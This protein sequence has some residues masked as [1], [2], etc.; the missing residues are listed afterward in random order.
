MSDVA[1]RF[2]VGSQQ[3]I[4]T[5]FDVEPTK[6]IETEFNLHVVNKDHN[7]L[8]NRDLPNQHSMEAITGLTEA[9]EAKQDTLEAGKGI[10]ING[11][12]ISTSGDSVGVPQ[13]ANV[14]SQ[15]LNT[16]EQATRRMNEESRLGFYS[17]ICFNLNLTKDQILDKMDELYIGIERFKRNRI[18]S[19][20]IDPEDEESE[21]VDYRN[22]PSF[23]LQN[24]KFVHLDQKMFCYRYETGEYGSDDPRDYIVFY[25]DAEYNSYQDMLDEDPRIWCFYGQWIN[26]N[27]PSCLNT[28]RSIGAFSDWEE[29]A[30]SWERYPDGDLEVFVNIKKKDSAFGNYIK[31]RKCRSYIID[32]VKKYFWSEDWNDSTK[33]VYTTTDGKIPDSYVSTINYEYKTVNDYAGMEYVQR[34]DLDYWHYNSDDYDVSDWVVSILEPA[35]LRG[36]E[37]GDDSHHTPWIC[38]WMDYP[39]QP[40]LLQDCEVKYEGGWKK[41]KDVIANGDEDNLPENITF[42]YP[43]NT[44]E[45]WLRFSAWQKR[46]MYN[47][48]KEETEETEETKEYLQLTQKQALAFAWEWDQGYSVTGRRAFGR[49][50][51]KYSGSGENTKI[52]EYIHFNLY[53][54]YNV[55][56]GTKSR[57]TPIKKRLFINKV[58]GGSGIRD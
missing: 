26:G 22:I 33:E 35:T 44:A 56:G 16:A 24:D 20:K 55:Y 48:F 38:Y 43:Y 51:N 34:S 58:S 57:S 5:K 30:S 46:C 4:E 41:L 8:Y 19:G 12:V 11:N 54:P 31:Q 36:K 40:V 3:T 28:L 39:L 50:R 37:W 2:V 42:R 47:E 27:Q 52:C 23:K 18:T 13:I 1:A 29:D 45:L 7:E 9:L 32:G 15:Q 14:Y 49:Q 21:E 53:T 17:D 25:T 10:A 6:A